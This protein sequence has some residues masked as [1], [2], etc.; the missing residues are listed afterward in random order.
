[1]NILPSLD[2]A[3][4]T[5]ERPVH[6]MNSVMSI[7]NFLP[8]SSLH[9]YDDGS[10]KQEQQ[11]VLKLLGN[12][13]RIHTRQHDIRLPG[14]RGGLY[15]N[16]RCALIDAYENDADYLFLCQDDVQIV[17]PVTPQDMQALSD[18]FRKN[19]DALSVWPFFHGGACSWRLREDS[20]VFIRPESSPAHGFQDVTVLNLKRFRDAGLEIQPN[21]AETSRAAR[22][23]GY[24]IV[25]QVY[26]WAAFTPAPA[27]RRRGVSI[28][29]VLQPLGDHLGLGFYPWKSMPQTDQESLL[30]RD[31]SSCP[32]ATEWLSVI[33]PRPTRMTARAPSLQ[34]AASE[35]FS[36]VRKRNPTER[37]EQTT[38]SER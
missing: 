3:V 26:P 11:S 38:D 17:R 31:P 29:R 13:A 1:M 36:R 18:A 21:E 16:M 30:D 12:Y 23:A 25:A 14:P 15:D 5:Y 24:K 35:L 37:P 4:F 2:V 34:E 8:H 22:K 20:G 27:V 19:R 33:G 9:V 32:R 7:V 6:L 28:H 10:S